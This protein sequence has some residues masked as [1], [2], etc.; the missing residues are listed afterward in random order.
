ML[1]EIDIKDWEQLPIQP[2]YNVPRKTYI[3]LPWMA[4]DDVNNVIYFDHLDGAYS[5]CLTMA[6]EI[7]HLS[8]VAEVVPLQKPVDTK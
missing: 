8:A 1:S 4:D 7:V 5:Y 6:N 3:K 2:L